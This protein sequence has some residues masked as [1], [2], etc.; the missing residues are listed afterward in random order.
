MFASSDVI[1]L[2]VMDRLVR[3]AMLPLNMFAGSDAIWLW[4]M[5]MPVNAVRY[6]VG[7]CAGSLKRFR[8]RDVRL[9][10]SKFITRRLVFAWKMFSGNEVR[11]L[12]YNLIF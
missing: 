9:L 12:L 2:C 4:S 11:L 10:F 3:F 1:W 5:S 6:F 7:V 8:G